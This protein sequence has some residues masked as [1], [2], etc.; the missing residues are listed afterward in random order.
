MAKK[1]LLFL[2]ISLFVTALAA[3]G[4]IQVFNYSGQPKFCDSCH[5]VRP[6][7]KYANPDPDSII[8]MHKKFGISCIDCHSG[9]EKGIKGQVEARKAIMNVAI[10]S[11]INS[12]INQYF[13]TNFT[14]NTS[15]FK[16]LRADCIK[17][18]S[19]SDARHLNITNTGRLRSCYSCHWV[20]SRPNDSEPHLS[21]KIGIGLHKNRTC[22]DCHGTDFSIP[23]CRK[24]HKTHIEGA[25]WNNTVCLGCHNDPHV[26]KKSYGTFNATIPKKLCSACHKEI[27]DKLRIYNSKHNK[28][29][30]CVNCHP[31]HKQIKDCFD[32]HTSHHTNSRECSACHPYV[33]GCMDC[34]RNPHAPLSGLPR[35]NTG[36]QMRDY[37]K[38]VGKK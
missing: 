36:D 28:K 37:A 11:K 23:F 30:L 29:L 19:L 35:I 9:S 2:T 18:H 15:G 33:S 32:C 6:Y 12:M 3:Y 5:E 8:P 31:V 1:L 38:M 20:H 14:Y 10:K 25:D 24:C 34:H 22:M 27:Y 16:S 17:C 26:P 21:R 7:Q 13:H 4:A